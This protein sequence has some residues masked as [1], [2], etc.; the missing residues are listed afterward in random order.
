M[1]SFNELEKDIVPLVDLEKKKS[2]EID[3]KNEW[4]VWASDLLEE[5]VK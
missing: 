4:I 3:I 2:Y 5:Y 1:N